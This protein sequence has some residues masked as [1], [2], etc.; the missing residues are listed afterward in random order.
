[1]KRSDE[2]KRLL[3]DALADDEPAGFRDAVLTETLRRARSRKHWRQ[4][5]RGALAVAAVVLLTVLVRMNLPTTPP[6]AGAPIENSSYTLVKTQP[7]V[8]AAWV[9]TMPLRPEQ[10]A[11]S[12]AAIERVETDTSSVTVR[13]ITDDELLALVGSRTAALVRCGPHCEQLIFANPED[14]NGFPIN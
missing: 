5:R 11:V 6:L 10:R 13:D 12:F 8:P 4:A 14:E 7:L 1:M 3:A 2:H 9:H